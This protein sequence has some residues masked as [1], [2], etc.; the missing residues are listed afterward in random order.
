MES[1]DTMKIEVNNKLMQLNSIIE[2]VQNYGKEEFDKLETFLTTDCINYSNEKSKIYEEHDIDNTKRF[3][4]FESISDKW[5]RENFH[6]DVLY[7][8]LN[9]DTKEIGRKYFMQEF[10]KFLG[11]ED[12]FDCNSDF[13]VIKE[14]PTGLIDWEEEDGQKREKPGYIDLLI[15]NDTQAIIIENKI[16]YAP[17]MEN[18]LVRYMKYVDELL[19]IKE[20]TVVYLSLIGDKKPPLDS[21]SKDLDYYAKKLHDERILKEVCAVNEKHGLA[22]VFLKNCCTRLEEEMNNIQESELKKKCNIA[23][24]YIDQYKSLLEHLGGR[25]YMK[26]TEKKLIEEIYSNK[27]ESNGKLEAAKAFADLWNRKDSI[28]EEILADKFLESFTSKR[29]PEKKSINDCGND[30]LFESKKNGCF[31][32]WSGVFW[33]GF[34]AFEGEKFSEECQKALFEKILNIPNGENAFKN[35]VQIGCTIKDSPTLIEDVMKAL[36]ILF[37]S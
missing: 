10:V 36:E 16:N 25:A 27:K 14:Q 8:I 9:P 35:E 23:S 11:I 18:Q 15:K 34:T 20:Y 17:D 19:G 37:N 2:L 28:L 12:R 29:L 24:V 3:N 32:F 30:Y 13:K 6:S 1:C 7:T 4:F 31:V 33:L 21:Y 5:Y 26:S 22:N